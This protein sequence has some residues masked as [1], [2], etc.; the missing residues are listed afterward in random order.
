M[1]QNILE[2]KDG[3]YELLGV[4]ET[5]I[6]P[7]SPG[8]TIFVHVDPANTEEQMFEYG[9]KVKALLPNNN[10]LVL[11]KNVS[12]R[13]LPMEYMKDSVVIGKAL[14]TE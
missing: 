10:V 7:A 1:S 11:P 2:N 12:I 6:L 4:P 14:E 13:S 3:L 8:D 5:Y 9:K